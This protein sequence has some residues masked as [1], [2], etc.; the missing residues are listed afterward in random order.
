MG[1]D[2]DLVDMYSMAVLS[3]YSCPMRM[4][5]PSELSAV[6]ALFHGLQT[7]AITTT[8]IM[9]L[10]TTP[11]IQEI[12]DALNCSTWTDSCSGCQSSD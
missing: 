6:H 4:H 10:V 2:A 7:R 12:I 9:K 1:N 8:A 3:M 5:F 11:I